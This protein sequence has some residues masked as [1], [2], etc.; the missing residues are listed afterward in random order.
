MGVLR[1]ATWNLLH[2]RSP[3][4]G[5]V[6]PAELSR[7]VKLLDADI[8]AVQEADRLQ[9]RS[10][11]ADQTA[12]VAEAAGA[13]WWRYVPSLRGNP[14]TPGADWKPV[15]VADGTA[16]AC[17][18]YGVGLVSRYPVA[19]WRVRRFAPPPVAMPLLVPGR[20]GLTW[21][22]DEPRAAIAALIRGPRGLL[23]V[24]AAHLSTVPGWNVQQLWRIARW[25][26]DL[27]GPQLL[28]GDFNLPGALPGLITGWTPLA[29]ART[30]PSWRPMV[31]FDHVLAQGVD[32][33]GV[34]T[35]EARRL[36]VSDHCALRV[37]VDDS[38]LVAATRLAASRP[39]IREPHALSHR[40]P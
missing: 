11:L 27:P 1:I 29:R 7:C 26:D 4:E 17:P 36:P 35:S 22:P 33:R 38:A 9:P 25:L 37:E 8:L 28:L 16:V 31:Q 2:G 12:L 34:V 23:T 18:T 6:D 5:S 39:A 24:A 19:H 3:A 30:Y 20:P 32:P 14:G 15:S 21:V 40:V 10:G 13:P